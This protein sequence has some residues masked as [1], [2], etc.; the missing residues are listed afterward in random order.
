MK[1]LFVILVLS[2][3]INAVTSASVIDFET[4]DEFTLDTENYELAGDHGGC[5]TSDNS[6][7]FG[8]HYTDPWDYWGGFAASNRAIIG[9]DD[10]WHQYTSAP[11][12]DHT[13][14]AGGTYAIGYND[15]ETGVGCLINFTE[16]QDVKGA[17]FTNVAWTA[18]YIADN[19]LPG[20]YY[21]L[22]ITAYDEFMEE[23]GNR[24]VNLTAVEDWQFYNTNFE[25]AYA[26][27]ITMESSDDW[28]PYYFCID[29]I[30]SVSEPSI[31]AL[32][33]A[34]FL[35]LV[36]YGRGKQI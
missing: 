29:D 36:G 33:T 3:T 19:Y 25:D 2:M 4:I 16:I 26:L 35:T 6:L 11:G 5:Y 24:T 30:T 22:R 20:D 18:E 13:T 14:G 8:Y 34:G 7:F 32:L 17:W 10:T 12:T 15:Y 1:K 28:T 27:G 31:I 23:I 9:P 21:H